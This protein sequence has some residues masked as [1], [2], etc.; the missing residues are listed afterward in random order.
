M[1]YRARNARALLFA[2]LTWSAC[3]QAA[4]VSDKFPTIDDYIIQ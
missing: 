4:Q 1:G 2:I 3:G